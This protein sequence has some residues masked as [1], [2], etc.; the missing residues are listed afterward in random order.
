MND[1]GGCTPP[2]GMYGCGAGF[3][4]LGAEYCELDG[5]DV[6]TI[7]STYTCKPLPTACGTAP[8]CACLSSVQCGNFCMSIADGGL[9][10]TCPGG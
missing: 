4:Q 2:A 9:Q 8:S 10:V 3:C 1:L 5:S 6:A 7:P